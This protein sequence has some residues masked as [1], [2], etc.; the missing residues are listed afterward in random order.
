MKWVVFFLIVV[1]FA[2]L[3]FYQASSYMA[4]H[5][6]VVAPPPPVP[7]TG[8]IKLLSE[9]ELAALTKKTAEPL[10]AASPVASCYEWGS[11]NPADSAR[12]LSALRKLELQKPEIQISAKVVP[13]L[14]STRYWVYIPAQK[15]M[16]AAQAK[17]EEIK[18]LGVSDTLILQDAQWHNA[19]SLGMF[20]DEALA[21]RFIDKLHAMGVKN[22]VKAKR[23]Q[24]KNETSYVIRHVMPEQLVKLNELKPHFSTGELKQ[25][26]CN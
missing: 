23:G 5:Q 1:N 10:P 15:T 14:E 24:G 13:K 3:G 22:A 25:I 11:F 12:A 6:E 2:L 4:E 8:S 19:I 16:E 20:K 7:Y 26:D 18:A 9:Q 17:N 21:N